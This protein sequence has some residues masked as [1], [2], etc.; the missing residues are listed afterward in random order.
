MDPREVPSFS[1]HQRSK[2]AWV[3]G[4][5]LPPPNSELLHV[6]LQLRRLI[7]KIL[8]LL[9]THIFTWLSQ[10]FLCFSGMHSK[11]KP[12]KEVGRSKAGYTRNKNMLPKQESCYAVC[13]IYQHYSFISSSVKI[14][15]FTSFSF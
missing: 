11:K 13:L 9:T 2:F 12:E 14:H 5:E 4:A 15:S 3:F 7:A 6:S 8:F 10:G 1:I